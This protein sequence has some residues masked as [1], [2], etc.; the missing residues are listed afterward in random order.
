[1]NRYIKNK[2]L[3]SILIVF[4][5]LA[6]SFFTGNVNSNNNIQEGYLTSG[7]FNNIYT[8]GEV[9]DINYLNIFRAEGV[10]DFFLL[11]EIYQS[12]AIMMPNQ[13]IEPWLASC[14]HE[15]NVSDKNI[16][17]FD[18]VTGT[19]E[20]VSYI[21]LLKIRPG[22]AW[23][24]ITGKNMDSTYVFTNYTEFN[25]T[26]GN[27][28]KYRYKDFYNV[29]TGKNQTWNNITM[30]TYYLQAAD[31]ILSW[32]ILFD[33]FDYT[34]EF[35]N[36]VNIVPLNNLTV[37]YYLD[38][39]SSSFVPCTLTVPVI[40]YHIWINHDYSSTPGLW[41]YS[42]DLPADS[43]YNS[44]NLDY[45]PVTGIA[46]GLV[47][48]GPFMIVNGSSYA[49]RILFNNYW[50]LSKN[51]SFFTVKYKN[52]GMYYPKI[53]GIKMIFFAEYSAAV[54]AESKGEIY[55]IVLP[56][57]PSFIPTLKAIP[58]TY[59]Y[60]KVST[61][62]NYVQMNS[63]EAPY[64]ITAFRQAIEYAVNKNYIA[65]VVFQGYDIPGTSVVPVSDTL[66]HDNN[67]PAYNYNPNLSMR[68]ISGIKGMH[69]INNHWYY[70]NKMVTADIQ[71][72]SASIDPNIV[73]AM[74][75]IAQELDSIGIKT[76]VTEEASETACQNTIDYNFNMIT[77]PITGIAGYPGGFFLE[78]YN[79][80]GNGTGLY[81][82]PFTSMAFNNRTYTGGQI[83]SLLNNLTEELNSESSVDKMINTSDEIQLIAADEATI[84][85]LGYRID[86]IPITN[87][88][89]TG[90]IKDNLGIES[91]WYWNFL[92][93]H[94]KSF[95]QGKLRTGIG[96][97]VSTNSEL[98][99]NGQYGNAT[100][101]VRYQNGTPVYH[102]MVFIGESPPGII[103]N[104]SSTTGFTNNYGTYKFE[105]KIIDDNQLIYSPG[106][107][108]S[109]NITAT[110]DLNGYRPVSNYTDV[111]ASPHQIRLIMSGSTV[112]Y[113]GKYDYINI[114]VLNG[115]KPVSGYS[116]NIQVLSGALKIYPMPGQ[117]IYNTSNNYIGIAENATLIN[118]NI[119]GV[120][121]ETGSNG[122]IELK[123]GCNNSL[124]FTANGDL[125]HT[126]IFLGNYSS[127]V[128]MPGES[129]YTPI[130]EL[131]SQ[132]HGNY[133]DEEPVE[134]P[135]TVSKYI[136][137]D[138]RIDYS[139]NS[140]GTYNISAYASLNKE[141]LN[142]YNISLTA[143]NMLGPNRGFFSDSVNG[144][145]PNSYFAS[146]L[147]PEVNITTVNGY[148][149]TTF[150]PWFYIPLE[151]PY[152]NEFITFIKDN[153]TSMYTP[154][155]DFIIS[156]ISQ[157][158]SASSIIYSNQSIIQKPVKTYININISNSVRIENS[159][160]LDSGDHVLNIILTSGSLYGPGING[161][162]K[163]IY[164][165]R[166]SNY[167]AVNGESHYLLNVNK[168]TS[169]EIVYNGTVYK[170]NIYANT[171]IINRNSI[172]LYLMIIFIV[173]FIIAMLLLI[174]K[175]NH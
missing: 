113:P 86:T 91:F 62:Y 115:S 51:P 135:V 95:T 119:T 161:T 134:I 174:I 71:V 164:N 30:K 40:P 148:A 105:F 157:N 34:G 120:Y 61:G 60:D 22:I 114:T 166:S 23:T 88:T 69:F 26:S 111:Y 53:S 142:N 104:V 127:G 109:I 2:I 65:S 74:E 154:A 10:C 37:E 116:Y 14:Y 64:N 76:T 124:N 13:S 108:N 97:Y 171:Y 84:I 122:I 139:M 130:M 145:N 152:N 75:V 92:S 100:V 117:G 9:G 16:K 28:Y 128:S 99:Y 70:H 54:A 31:I 6:T 78:F 49:G 118:Y 42:P 125:I 21:W 112:L 57:P 52:L 25:S 32:K 44:W 63:M 68:I 19:N 165:G 3:I 94:Y 1:M 85:N 133:G 150:Y 39:Q 103:L 18:P 126:W 98:Y 55:S 159:F 73:E 43:S 167:T 17:T 131:G 5:L 107:M 35:Q 146:T 20:N 136:V 156:A 82:G 132:L 45:N 77:C 141:P 129:G 90:I 106:Y 11:N 102:A 147:M 110:A 4:I 158:S 36:I 83:T 8:L 38:N 27:V 48:N 58:D 15:Y 93:L 173:A 143:Q 172:Y 144:F 163:L 33:S 47:G 149:N 160:I 59:I 50:E 80:Q 29:E 140:N 123:L 175:R 46:G 56:P 162:Y 7:S 12:P 121:G 168:N 169:I 87:S 89:F 138:I 151:N 79:I 81:Y 153:I 137:P 96:V 41:N 72:A 66:W 101:S 24:D 170:Y 155:D 67:I